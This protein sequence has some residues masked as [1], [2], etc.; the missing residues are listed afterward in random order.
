MV[1]MNR[2][3]TVLHDNLVR[4]DDGSEETWYVLSIN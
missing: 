4:I 2:G 3:A 1:D